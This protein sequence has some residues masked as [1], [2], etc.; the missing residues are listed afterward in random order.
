MTTGPHSSAS[1]AAAP[2]LTG[3]LA[4]I[5]LFDLCQFL[6][7]NRKTGTLTV[8]AAGGPG[9]A[10]FTFFEGEL[11]TA[12]DDSLREG[13]EVVLAAVQWTEGSFE[14]VQWPVPP[15]R[16]MNGSTENILLDAARQLD[17]MQEK[18]RSGGGRGAAN[19]AEQAFRDKQARAA[20]IAEAFCS[21]VAEGDRSR[22][23]AGWR[24]AAKTRLLE[25]AVERL[26]LCAD[27][28]AGLLV[29]GRFEEIPEAIPAE[30]SAWMEQLAPVS[31][32]AP[33]KTGR[34]RQGPPE[35]RPGPDDLWGLRVETTDGDLVFVTRARRAWPEMQALPL[36][37][38]EVAALDAIPCGLVAVLGSVGAI[39]SAWPAW[40][41]SAAWIARRTM[42][43]PATGWIVEETPR[44]HW[45]GLPGR[46]RRVAPTRLR[47]AGALE[48]LART[49]RPS[50]LVF[51]GLPRPDLLE[52]AARLGAAGLLV[53]VVDAADQA[54]AWLAAAE[55]RGSDAAAG[56]DPQFAAT[57]VVRADRCSDG[58]GRPQQWTRWARLLLPS[59][60]SRLPPADTP[61]LSR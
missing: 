21:L 56:E 22:T 31:A 3:R 45:P 8:R 40:E 51:D 10:Y 60:P 1:A 5:S 26:V 43:R 46:W 39:P 41:A 52:E 9:A 38:E 59:R 50:V 23:T 34:A 58:T 13:A 16:R 54:S 42:A 2:A 4:A 47:M 36:T 17:E 24:E 44:Y 11:C 61:A 53:V 7:L 28:R 27:G 48:S 15:D 55:C 29:D 30:V 49:S 37:P 32:R 35:A 14:F 12:L 33:G 20:S 19:S 6:M 18:D 57:A 25:P